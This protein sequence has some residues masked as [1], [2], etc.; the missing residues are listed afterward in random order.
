MARK[1]LDGIKVLDFCWVAVGPMTTKYLAE[2]G[3]TVVRV[4]SAKR[5]ETLR[6]AAPFKDGIAGIDRSGYFANYNANKYG[7]TIDM[8]HPG[9][10]DLALRI[11]SWADL[12]T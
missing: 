6:T 2:Y 7:V 5:P 9:A 1:P 3:A 12:V 8:R 11:A 4:E 10:R